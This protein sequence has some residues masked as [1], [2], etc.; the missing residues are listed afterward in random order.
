MTMVACRQVVGHEGQVVAGP[1]SA[2]S[3]MLF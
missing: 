2:V 3:C 1:D